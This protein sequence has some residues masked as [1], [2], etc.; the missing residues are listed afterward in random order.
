MPYRILSLDGGGAWSLIQARTLISLYGVNT[1]GHEV[2]EEFDLIAANSGGSLVLGGLV[3]NMKLSDLLTLFLDEQKRK[4]IFS[5]TTRITDDVLQRLIGIG[6]KYSTAAKLPAIERLLP[7]TG[8]QPLRKV[9]SGII[10]PGGK[11]LHLLVIGFN[12]DRNRAE[13][14]RS[15]PAGGPV[16]GMG[17]P[18][19]ITLA[20]SIHASTNAPVNYF[21]APAEIPSNSDRF[22]DGGVTGCNNP[23]LAAVIEAMTLQVPPS[24]IRALSLGTATVCLPLAAPG[25]A[26]SPFAAPRAA[27]SLAGDIGKLTQAI[28]DDPPDADTFIAHAVTG[29]TAGLTHPVIS[30]VV[31]LSPLITPV[32]ADGGW[33]T[34]PG[35]TPAQFEHICGLGMDAVESADVAYIDNWCQLWLRDLA[36]NQPIRMNGETLVPELGYGRYSEALSA[37][38]S[39][40]PQ[41]SHG[42]PAV[43]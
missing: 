18:A 14:F 27:P 42:T 37:W 40:F 3:E 26:A 16:W 11:P 12:Y 36:P 28:L 4:S 34:P 31:R 5:P 6:P 41:V 29:G 1:T 15:Q 20:A 25:A 39:L 13:F 43:A 9:A 22:W 35:W 23:V 17:A 30:R 2:L 33:T 8:T 21:D 32:A 24:E 38:R 10:G 7:N 19:D